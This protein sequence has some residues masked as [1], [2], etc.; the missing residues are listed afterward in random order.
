MRLKVITPAAVC[1]DRDVSRIVAEAPNGYFGMLPH[2]IDFVTQVVPGILLF[3]PDDGGT[4][5]FVA[6]NSG[7]L[8]K[9]GDDVRVAVRGAI[10]GEDLRVLQERVAAE[11]RRQDED[12]RSARSALTRLEATMV[13]R[14]RDLEKAGR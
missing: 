12:E 10:E 3:E 4:E 8:V 7:T 14:F 1:V 11:F 5:R 2:H 13:R 6:I 9:C